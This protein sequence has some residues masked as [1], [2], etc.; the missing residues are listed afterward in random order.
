MI[1]YLN[2]RICINVLAHDLENAKEIYEAAEGHVVVGV[3]SINY[4]TVEEAVTD[5]NRYAA[6][7]DNNLSIGLGAGNPNQWKAVGD[8]S[9]HVKANHINQ[10]FT[11]VA[12]TRAKVGDNHDSH[13]NALV[14]P[15]G[16]PGYLAIST[17]PTSSHCDEPAIVSID[18]AIA[19]VKDMGGNALKFFPMKG[20]QVKDELKAVAKACAQNNLCLEPTG[21]IDL[22]NYEEIMTII[23][24]AGVQHVIPHIYSSIIDAD[25]GKTKVEDVKTIM[26]I[27]RKLLKKI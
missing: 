25:T 20:L 21:G 15:T 2:D 17:G 16:K 19:M 18:T 5:M 22:E 11:A 3:L 1:P 10:V 26:D 14:S 4:P 8:I 24:D 6:A 27:N 13:I 9:E 23:L 7:L 12:Y